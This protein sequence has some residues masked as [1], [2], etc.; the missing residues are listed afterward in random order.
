MDLLL[1]FYSGPCHIVKMICHG[2]SLPHFSR[3]LMLLMLLFVLLRF[4]ISYLLGICTHCHSFSL[5]LIFA[6]NK[7]S[8]YGGHFSS[9]SC[10]HAVYSSS[11]MLSFSSSTVFSCNPAS[12]GS[13]LRVWS[14]CCLF[15]HSYHV[16]GAYKQKKF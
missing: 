15:K 10:H 13:M 14:A 12:L 11:S 2:S 7:D 16:L 6:L 1:R 4:N 3:C 5:N 9:P 8:L